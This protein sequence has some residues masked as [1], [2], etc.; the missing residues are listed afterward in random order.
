M[1]TKELR[2][3]TSGSCDLP[4]DPD[5]IK[6]I[7]QQLHDITHGKWTSTL[8]FTPT[9]TAIQIEKFSKLDGFVEHKHNESFTEIIYDN[10]QNVQN[11]DVTAVIQ[12]MKRL[13]QAET[14]KLTPI[15]KIYEQFMKNALSVGQIYSTFIEIVMCNMYITNDKTV[16]RY[17]LQ[18]D[19]SAVPVKKLNIMRLH[20]VVSKLLGLLYEPN[21]QSIC[22]FANTTNPLPT[23][24]NT[25]LERFWNEL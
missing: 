16:L 4:T 17:A 15:D 7:K 10:V 9:L 11:R 1:K 12:T 5:I 13:T 21:S 24:S 6:I 20:S 14:G 22:E 3:H 25:V 23:T 19:P 18:K 2:V 8:H